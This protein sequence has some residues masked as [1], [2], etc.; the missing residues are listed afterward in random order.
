[1]DGT[2]HFQVLR[3]LQLF[4]GSVAA[5]LHNP[6]S[7]A[8]CQ[9]QLRKQSCAILR[10]AQA[11]LRNPGSCASGVAK[12]WKLSKPSFA[13][14]V[15]QSDQRGC[16]IVVAQS[17]EVAESD[18]I[19]IKLRYITLHYIALHYITFTF[20][21]L[22]R[23]TSQCISLHYITLHCIAYITIHCTTLQHIIL[24]CIHACMHTLEYIALRCVAVHYIALRYITLHLI[25]LGS[26]WHLLVPFPCVF[27]CGAFMHL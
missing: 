13:I 11:E 2:C 19:H 6:G 5:E 1:M 18:F 8:I 9:R 14:L 21:T 4:G 23:I 10:V 26:N 16:A 25:S 12:S 22:H 17:G 27:H 7:C 24:H 20:I 3:A 15:A